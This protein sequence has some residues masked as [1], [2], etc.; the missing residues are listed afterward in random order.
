MVVNSSLLQNAAINILLCLCSHLSDFEEL[1]TK[2]G[3]SK[4]M[5]IL[6]FDRLSR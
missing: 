3:I 2:N 5:E 4:Y 6:P 1:I